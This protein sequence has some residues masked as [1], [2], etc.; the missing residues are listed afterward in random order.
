MPKYRNITPEPLTV[1]TETGMVTVQPDA[2]L[3]VSQDFADAHYFQTGETGE[4]ALWAPVDA[5]AKKT[6]DAHKASLSAPADE[7]P[8]DEPPADEPPVPSK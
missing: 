4:G 6:A 3:T 8:A 7:P 5:P 2:I 1:V